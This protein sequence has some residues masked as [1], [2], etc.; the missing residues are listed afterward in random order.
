MESFGQ[1][2]SASAELI[3]S[4]RLGLDVR[5]TGDRRG[6]VDVRWRCGEIS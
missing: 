3:R 6:R 1:F 2:P 5:R 4:H